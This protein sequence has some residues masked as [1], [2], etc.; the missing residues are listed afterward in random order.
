MTDRSPLNDKPARDYEVGKCK[1]PK[2]TQFPH[3][4]RN[5][6]GKKRGTKD[7]STLADEELEQKLELQEGGKSVSL[8]KRQLVMKSLVNKAAK[9]DLKA[10]A[11]LIKI[12]GVRD[13]EASLDLEGITPEMIA[14]FV[15][16]LP[17]EGEDLP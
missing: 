16:R 1:P 14:S 17:Q 11:L 6:T 9:G 2:H 13:A 15:T 5:R 10:I 4:K 12:C 3:Q 7:W 8:N